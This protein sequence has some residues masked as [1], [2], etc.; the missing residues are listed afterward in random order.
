MPLITE[1]R[2]FKYDVAFSFLKEDAHMAQQ[3]NDLL[4]QRVSTFIYTNR[5]EELVAQEG[6]AR[7]REVFETE[8]RIVVVLFR[9]KWGTTPW[10]RVEEDAFRRP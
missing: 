10:T 1:Q 2:D 3:L 9:E 4:Q 7:F 5:Q 6:M 8:A